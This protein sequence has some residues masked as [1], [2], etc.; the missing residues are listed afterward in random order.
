[1]NRAVRIRDLPQEAIESGP[2][3][4]GACYLNAVELTS[5]LNIGEEKFKLMRAEPGFP[6]KDSITNKWFWPSVKAW[7]FHRHG[8]G[9]TI[10][11]GEDGPENW[12]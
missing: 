11:E 6:P 10:P 12:G 2:G 7:L 8:I 3:L 1:M 5:K 4:S 9:S